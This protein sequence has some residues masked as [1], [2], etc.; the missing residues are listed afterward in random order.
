MDRE[1]TF[2]VSQFVAC[3]EKF[4]FIQN[5]TLP[6]LSI[7]VIEVVPSVTVVKTNDDLLAG[8]EQEVSLVVRTGSMAFR[9]VISHI[10]PRCG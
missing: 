10:L 8:T 7:T 5:I 3:S 2:V 9:E 4:E 6:K 1:G